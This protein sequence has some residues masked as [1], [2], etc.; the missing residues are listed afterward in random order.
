MSARDPYDERDLRDEEDEEEE[1]RARNNLWLR[2]GLIA[3]FV[4]AIVLF[5]AMLNRVFGLFDGLTGGRVEP[6]RELILGDPTAE[7]GPVLGGAAD[8]AAVDP[9]AQVPPVGPPP[10]PPPSIGPTFEQ[11]YFARGG[12]TSLGRP[13][14]P[15]LNVN[16]REIQWFERARVEH[17]PEL[18]G[19]PYEVQLGRLGV[20]FTQGREFAR[21]SFFVSTPEL[22]YFPETSHGVGGAFLRYWEQNGGLDRFGL[23]ISEE[24]DEVL[25]D[26]VAHRVQYFERARLEYHPQH[27]GTSFEVQIG[28]LGTAL[29]SND[30]RPST[31]QPVPTQVPLP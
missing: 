15:L 16:G 11:F 25:A 8:E 1:R 14:T 13:L 18:A 3:L 24:F 12:E 26:G 29:L 5:L 19:T 22:R 28:L 20:E 30:A 10:G 21:Q 17:W 23:P 27:A 9:A 4:L 6:T 2:A 31:I 7:P